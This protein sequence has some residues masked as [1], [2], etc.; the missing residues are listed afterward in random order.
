MDKIKIY[1]DTSIINFLHADDA[2]KQKAITM[3][4]FSD[5]LSVYEVL[6]S[7]VVLIEIRRTTNAKRRNILLQVIEKYQLQ[8]ISI[9]GEE[10][11]MINQLADSYIEHKAIPPAKHED[12]LHVAICTYYQLDVLLSWNFRHLANINKQYKI[13]SVN[14]SLGFSK[15]LNLLTPMQVIYENE[16]Q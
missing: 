11:T 12:A 10:R 13:N 2:P 9:L 14:K 7:E 1:L 8:A 6:I 5:Y 16:G 3:E 15:E 4:F